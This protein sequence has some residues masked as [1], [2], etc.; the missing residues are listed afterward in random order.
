MISGA[1][2]LDND[3]ALE[4]C[5]CSYADSNGSRHMQQH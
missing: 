3:D 4:Y 2:V 1:R 5:Q